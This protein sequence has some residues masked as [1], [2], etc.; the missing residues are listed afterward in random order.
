MKFFL[1]FSPIIWM[2]LWLPLSFCFQQ[3]PH[4]PIFATISPLLGFL[5]FWKAE[6]WMGNQ[7]YELTLPW[8]VFWIIFSI[9][10]FVSTISEKKKEP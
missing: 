3:N 5:S 9:T 6:A 2:I 10:I 8:L 1:V 4:L 7:L